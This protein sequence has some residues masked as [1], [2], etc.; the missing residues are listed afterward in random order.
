MTKKGGPPRHL[1]HEQDEWFYA[2][3]GEFVVEIGSQRFR[4]APGDS[5]LAPREVPQP[6]RLSGMSLA[7]C[8]LPSA[9]PMESR[10]SFA[11]E[12]RAPSIPLTQRIIG[13]TAWNS[14]GPSS[15]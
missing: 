7:R 14:L 12:P 6:M 11:E 9:Q 8:C 5:I 15:D 2:V 3:K 4:L 1:H 10:S 13:R